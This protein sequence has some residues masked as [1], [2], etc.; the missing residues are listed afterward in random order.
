MAERIKVMQIIAR[1]NVGGPA[2]IVAELMR[3]L[4]ASKFEQVLVTGYCDV[5]EADYLEEVATDIKATRIAGLGRSISLVTDLRAFIGLVA[6]IKKI[7][8]DVIHTH[9]AKA[10]VLGRLASIIAGRGAIRIHTF[11]GHLLHGYFSGWKTQLVIAIEKA[12]AG[13]THHLIAI[14]TVVKN[15]LLAAGI[16]KPAQFSVFFP[17]LPEP[18][19]F[20]RAEL[21]KE[22]ELDSATIYCTFVGR[23]TQIKRPDRLLD[24]AA[25]IAK[26]NVAVHFLV[27]G[28]GELFESSR[29]RATAKKL[30]ITFLGWRKDIDQ[31]FAASDIAILTSDNEG[32]PLTLIQGAQAG[33]PIVAPAV[34]SI[35][36]IVEDSKTGFL[37]APTASAMAA[38]LSQLVADSELR[39]QLGAAGRERAHTYFSL[40]RMLRDHT[41]IYNAPHKK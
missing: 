35:S 31:L 39:S 10:G 11:H 4:D 41:G 29:V 13:R 36:D 38:R 8:P 20:E 28:E 12:L 33:L 30:P 19:R 21:R 7:Q 18:K 24:V 17:G 3:G 23:L 34:G 22:L 15:D 6:M 5:N 1:M 25:E 26:Q 32:I 40:E 2:V 27:A 9:T 37:T 16:G 14:G